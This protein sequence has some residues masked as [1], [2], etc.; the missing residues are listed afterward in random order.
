MRMRGKCLPAPIS[1]S[2]HAYFASAAKCTA[3]SSRT[4][5]TMMFDVSFTFGS[6]ILTK[7]GVDA[8]LQ[9]CHTYSHAKLL[10]LKKRI[11][12]SGQGL[13]HMSD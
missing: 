1:L 11:Y 5:T 12:P 10:Y 9:L 6:F 3:T 8:L 4:V 13:A 7:A 2:V